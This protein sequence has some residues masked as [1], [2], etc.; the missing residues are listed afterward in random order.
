MRIT[1]ETVKGPMYRSAILEE[2]FTEQQV[3]AADIE[4]TGL[5]PRNCSVILGGLTVA[6]G[7]DRLAVQ[8]FADHPEEEAELLDRYV[9]MLTRYDVAVTFNGNSFDL[10]F[11]KKRMKA[12]GIDTTGLEAMYSFDLYRIL[13]KYSVL[14]ELLPDLKQK[15]VEKYMGLSQSR[16]DM[17]DGA[18]SVRL[19]YEYLESRGERREELLDQILLHNRD[20]IVKLTEIA[21]ILRQLDLH[22]IFYKE[23]FPV[24]AHG[25]KAV[26]HKIKTGRNGLKIEGAVSGDPLPYQS[27]TSGMEMSV[28]QKGAFTFRIPLEEVGGYQVTDLKMMGMDCEELAAL[29]GYESGYLILLDPEKQ[30]RYH[31][32][33]RLSGRMTAAL[34][35]EL[36]FQHLYR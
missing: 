22:E 5:S 11:L 21:H 23:G 4:T 8:Y 25:R 30:V 3:A 10:P 33:N 6:K 31:E 36:S 9:G 29:P 26:I 14:P 32:V 13:K 7:E 27:F 2:Y 1:Q 16:S 15:T 17:I 34:L 12:L 20:D 35:R 18:Q 24:K 28:D 19:Y